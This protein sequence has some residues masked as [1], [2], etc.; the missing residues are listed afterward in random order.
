TDDGAVVRCRAGFGG[1][2]VT[3]PMGAS[4]TKAVGEELARSLD[5]LA[6]LLQDEPADGTGSA[7]SVVHHATGQL[8]DPDTP[9]LVG[10]GQL[11]R[12][13]ADD[14]AQADP[15]ALAAEALRRAGQDSDTGDRL[16]RTADAVY[17]VASATWTY[18]DE[19]ALIAAELGAARA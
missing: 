18:R 2:P 17:T 12:R 9:V 11:V 19:S 8:L 16:L 10:A 6:G 15:A 7:A 5:N 4:L 1:D 14:A 13:D 3:G